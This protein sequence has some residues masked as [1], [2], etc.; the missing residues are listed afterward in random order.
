MVLEHCYVDAS[1]LNRVLTALATSSLVNDRD[2]TLLTLLQS[3]HLD[4]SV[5]RKPQVSA[6]TS[7]AVPPNVFCALLR[8]QQYTTPAVC[9]SSKLAL[10]SFIDLFVCCCLCAYCFTSTRFCIRLGYRST[11]LL[12]YS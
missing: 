5:P 11:R 8:L 1:N 9:M 6:C 4:T 3:T 7:V 10:P 12:Q 2:H